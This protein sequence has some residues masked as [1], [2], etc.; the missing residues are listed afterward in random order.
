MLYAIAYVTILVPFI[1]VD[2][3]WLTVMGSRLYRPT[4]GDILLPD[5][6][7]PPAVVFYLIYPI[8]IL[9]FATLPALKAGS[10]SPALMYG[11]LFGAMAYA[12]YDLTNFAT[13]RNWTLL[14]SVLDI[15]WGAIV[16]AIAAVAAYYLTRLIGGWMG[17]AGV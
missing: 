17:I 1:I 16:T 6:N 3:I 12:T 5:L 7:T 14:I 10:V 8:G 11:A 9:V 13:L 4:L 15:A 2:A